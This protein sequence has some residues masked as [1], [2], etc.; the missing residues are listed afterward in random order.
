MC[1]VADLYILV[2]VLVQLYAFSSQLYDEI[3]TNL[4]LLG[5]TAVEDKLQDGVPETIAT[6]AAVS[7]LREWHTAFSQA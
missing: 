4:Y 6:L 5:A 1:H 2:H 7:T 3:E